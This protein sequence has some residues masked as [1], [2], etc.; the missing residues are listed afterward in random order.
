M[1]IVKEQDLSKLVTI[2]A[3]TIEIVKKDFES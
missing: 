1:F 2:P 3:A